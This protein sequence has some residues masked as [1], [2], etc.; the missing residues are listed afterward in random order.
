MTGDIVDLTLDDSSD[1][2]AAR[3][4]AKRP[5]SPD[6]EDDEVMVLDEVVEAPPA[7]E[8]AAARAGELADG[9]ELRITDSSLEVRPPKKNRGKL[10]GP[11]S[12]DAHR[13]AR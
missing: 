12:A 6:S 8:A 10:A 2:E 1:D 9:E 11:P 3:R 7:T 5:R 13:P 4:P